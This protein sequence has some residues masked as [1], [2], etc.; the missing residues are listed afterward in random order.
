MLLSR[1]RLPRATYVFV[2]IERFI[3]WEQ[4][5]A[6]DLHQ[7]VRKAGLVCLNDPSKIMLRY[8]LL[9]TLH[10]TGFNPYNVYLA[11]D[12]PRP[13]RF[14]VFLRRENDHWGP[15]S[16]LLDS[17]AAL[18]R[19]LD[20]CR[21]DG[22]PLRSLLVVEW[23]AEP[24]APGVWRKFGTI[25]VGDAFSVDHANVADGWMIKGS[26]KGLA[27]EAMLRE[28][29]DAV[30]DNRFAAAL[31]PAFETAGIEFGRADHSSFG[32]REIVYEINTNP[33]FP[34]PSAQHSPIREE[35]KALARRR[36]AELL[37][38]IDSGGDDVNAPVRIARS[39]RVDFY[40]KQNGDRPWP[41]RP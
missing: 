2:D 31:A 20:Q 26:T 9:R 28:E 15:V 1:D 6:A 21:K 41:Q 23:C 33:V 36:M 10:A 5:L 25:R 3:P 34:P 14:P 38:R 29:R 40:R 18:D 8:E 13:Q 37:W 19:W 16:G 39:A 17:Q 7:A 35:A 24:I 12:R 32:G 4:E 30:A 11:V 22:G 27:S